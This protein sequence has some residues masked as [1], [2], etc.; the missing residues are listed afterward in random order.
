M[1]LV[2]WITV[3][4]LAFGLFAPTNATLLISLFVS[5]ASVSGAVLMILE[6]YRPYSGIIRLSSAPVRAALDQ[7]GR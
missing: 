1:T 7:L 2:F 5:A 6:F 4:F 3:I